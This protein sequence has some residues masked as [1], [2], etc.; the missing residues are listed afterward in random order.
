MV[1]DCSK[2]C[3]TKNVFTGKRNFS[4]NKAKKEK[5]T[6]FVNSLDQRRR[7]EVREKARNVFCDGP[8]SV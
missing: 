4:L 3:K 2:R 8:T 7:L 1:N 5:K 6:F